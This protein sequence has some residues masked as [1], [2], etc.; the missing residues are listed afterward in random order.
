MTICLSSQ[1]HLHTL[2]QLISYLKISWWVRCYYFSCHYQR[3]QKYHELVT[4]SSDF[5]MPSSLPTDLERKKMEKKEKT[6]RQKFSQKKS[7]IIS[8]LQNHFKTFIPAKPQV[9]MAFLQ[10][11]F[12]QTLSI[13]STSICTGH[14]PLDF[15]ET[16]PKFI[17]KFL[18]YTGN[19][20]DEIVLNLK[21]LKMSKFQVF[22]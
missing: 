18:P 6:A 20:L 4:A 13:T 22:T 2:T 12:K 21:N 10:L 9:D 5:P 1:K 8:A 7:L 3:Q 14:F 15:L 16:E 17:F 19:I 11:R